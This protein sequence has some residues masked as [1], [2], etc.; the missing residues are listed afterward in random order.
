MV[1]I[2]SQ[3]TV[4]NQ[5]VL[6]VEV[7]P[8][9]LEKSLDRAY[10]SVAGRVNVPGFRKGKAPR[11]MV[12]KVVGE[13]ALLER[14]LEILLPEAT[15]EAMESAGIEALDV[16]QV[17]VVGTDPVVFK[18]VIPVRPEFMLSDFRAIRKEL[19]PEPVTD[20]KIDEV[21]GQLRESGASWPEVAREARY[22]DM[23]LLSAK[24]MLEDKQVLERKDEEYLLQEGRD[25]LAP[26]L[27]P[28]L[29]GM[30]AGEEKD[31]TLPLK[32]AEGAEAPAEEKQISMHV[33]IHAV[34]EKALPE[35]NE[36]FAHGVSN[37]E[38][39]EG[40]RDEIRRRLE[41][42]GRQAAET[43]HR[44]EVVAEVVD[45]VSVE[46]PPLLIERE[47]DRMENRTVQSLQQ[48]GLSYERFLQISRTTREE[49][50]TRLREDVER[51]L[52]TSMVLGEVAK[53]AG[54]AVSEEDVD[55][56]I[57]DLSR[58]ERERTG[59]ADL[60]IGGDD[61]RR[62]VRTELLQQ[63]TI[64]YLVNIAKGEGGEAQAGASPS[65]AAWE[66]QGAAGEAEGGS[67]K[68]AVD[69]Q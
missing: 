43:R 32:P 27:M 53:E 3:E 22:D 25:I 20:E 40:L 47:L 26:G 19:A 34:K 18:A 28:H 8:E 29:V 45:G 1:K 48:Q 64:D 57:E 60:K 10:R 13:E 30:K 36:E 33:A 9:R 42:Q 21:I 54:L 39:V 15:Q 67:P 23:V 66:T 2:T 52:K 16:P 41:E 68:E 44:N 38:T 46:L 69:V 24:G 17:N 61:V 56:Y 37:Q 58:R 51:S 7:E 65:E 14:A 12:E 31:V 50:R 49:F 11:S 5:V 35:V 59:R 6:D 62:A 55:A 63:H 4:E